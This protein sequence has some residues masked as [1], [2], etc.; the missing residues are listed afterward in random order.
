[1]LSPKASTTAS[2]AS[3]ASF[4]ASP[5]AAPS[6]ATTTRSARKTGTRCMLHL[7][8]PLREECNPVRIKS[9]RDFW[10]GAMFAGCGAFFVAWSFAYYAMGSA[11]R[12]GPGYFP[13][14]LGRL[15]LLLG[16]GVSAKSLAA[17]GPRV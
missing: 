13:A 17:D 3:G 1:M 5:Q 2:G 10:A 8:A 11:G 6:A 4:G 14:V 12:M 15:L 7:P 9:P 16:A